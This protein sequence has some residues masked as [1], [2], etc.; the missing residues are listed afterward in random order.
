[1]SSGVALSKENSYYDFVMYTFPMLLRKLS[2]SRALRA[3]KK[4]LGTKIGNK[5]HTS[6]REVMAYDLPYL[7]MLFENKELAAQ[8]TA[9]FELNEKELAF[10][11]NTKPTTK[12]VQK[13][14]AEAEKIRLKDFTEKRHALSGISDNELAKITIKEPDESEE[15]IEEKPE[16]IETDEKQTKLF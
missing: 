2:G 16:P 13:I 8:Y 1:M 5:I 14:L 15:E 11:M 10:L 9:N 7:Q 6:S 12:K 3:M 4:E